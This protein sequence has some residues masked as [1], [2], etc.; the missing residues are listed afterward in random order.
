MDPAPQPTPLPP[1]VRT[2]L[3]I[4]VAVGA[5][6]SRCSTP[7][8][9]TGCSLVPSPETVEDIRER[10]AP[11]R[12]RTCRDVYPADTDVVRR[13][14]RPLPTAALIALFALIGLNLR[15]VFGAV[16][17]LLDDI[18]ADLALSGF[19]LSLLTAIPT[20]CLGSLAPPSS[21]LAL[22]IGH[23]Q[24]TA[25][26]LVVLTLAEALRLAGSVVALLYLS[27]FLTGAAIGAMSTMMPALLGYHLKSRP[28]LGA[29][30]YSTAMATASACAAWLA[31]PLAVSLGGWNRS[32]ASWALLTAV[33]AACWLLVL[34]RL[35]RPTTEEPQESE[36]NGLPWRSRAAWLLTAYFGLQTFVGFAAMTW[37][38][39][40]YR[41]AGWSADA[42]SRLLS[43]FFAIQIVGMLV[44]PAITDRTTDR[45]PVLAAVIGDLRARA[46]VFRGDAV[47]RLGRCGAVRTRHRR[48]L[49][50]RTRPARRRDAQ[51]RGGGPAVGDGLPA[52]LHLRHVG[53][54][55]RRSTARC[56]R[57]VRGGLLVPRPSRAF[58]L[59]TVV[60]FLRPTLDLLDRTPLSRD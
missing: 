42:A 38:A 43:V 14:E 7:S 8:R 10:T 58:G 60:P 52:L 39:P 16:P 13:T 12:T 49:R 32:L 56:H 1:R 29:G 50:G 21:R 4:D 36:G 18:G 37:I 54:G 34:P 51:P 6:R 19:A 3:A 5:S 22:R 30:V 20:L 9:Q 17:P 46:A 45:R 35:T 41:D 59:V 28:G 24:V 25:A 53:A 48:W 15:S 11:A 31:V 23:E 40:A 55:A 44:L 27:T 47:P 2:P 33:T 57:R 26:A